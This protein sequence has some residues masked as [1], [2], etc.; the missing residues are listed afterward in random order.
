MINKRIDE[1]FEAIKNSNEYQEY[2]NSEDRFKSLN[3]INKDEADTLLKENE[4][5]AKER[6]NYYQSLEEKK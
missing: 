4:E 6:Y 3:I 1:L 5:N 2:L